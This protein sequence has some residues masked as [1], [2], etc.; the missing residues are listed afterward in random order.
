MYF[1]R[2]VFFVVARLAVHKLLMDV[3]SVFI[4]ALLSGVFSHCIKSV[5]LEEMTH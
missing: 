3:V 2:V 1:P 4:V 5:T